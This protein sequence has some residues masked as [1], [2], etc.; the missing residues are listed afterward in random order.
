M[1]V[2]LAQELVEHVRNATLYFAEAHRVLRSGGLALFHWTTLWDAPK[3]HHVHADMVRAWRRALGCRRGGAPRYRNDGRTIPDGAH[4][5]WNRS[6][7][8]AHLKR[9]F[10]HGC[11]PLAARVVRY[12]YDDARINR[13]HLP[14][15]LRAVN[16][17]RWSS[18]SLSRAP[19]GVALG[20]H[21][22]AKARLT[23]VKQ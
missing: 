8:L 13:L 1:L 20:Y 4:L 12:I 2:A 5:T 10:G 21:A 11:P 3:G 15:M 23:L 7:M 22:T 17:Q 6:R 18:L 14:D 16:Q 9:V 19:P